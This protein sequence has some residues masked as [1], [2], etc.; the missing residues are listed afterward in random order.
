MPLSHEAGDEIKKFTKCQDNNQALIERMD[1]TWALYRQDKDRYNIPKK[2][3][4]WEEYI[5]NWAV[6]E[7][8]KIKDQL[9]YAKRRLWIPISD[10]MKTERE[11]LSAAERLANGLLYLADSLNENMPEYDSIQSSLVFYKVFRGWTAIRVMLREEDGKVIPDFIAWD[12]RNTGWLSGRDRLTWVCSKRQAQAQ[13]LKDEYP[14]WN[15]S[16]GEKD[17]GL[18]DVYDVYDCS[19][20]G[21][22]AENGVIIKG[23]YVVDPEPIKVGNF[24]LDYLPIRIKPGRSVPQISDGNSDNIK[25]R[26][27]DYLANNRLLI[28]ILSRLMSYKMTRAGQ[29]AKSPVLLGYDSVKGGEAIDFDSN[30]YTKGKVT[31]LDVGK[32]QTLLGNLIPAG[33][34]EIDSTLALTEG[35][36]SKGGIGRVGY[37]I[38]DQALPAQGIDILSQATNDVI[39]PFKLGVEGD[40]EWIASEY[41]RQFKNGGFGKIEVEG[42]DKGNNPYRVEVKAKEVDTNWRFKCELVPD[43]LRDISARIGIASQAVKDKLMSRKTAREY[44]QIVDDVDL[45]ETKI[46]Q[47]DAE[48]IAHI[49]LWQMAV[50]LDKDGD[51]MAAQIILNELKKLAQPQGQPQGQPQPGSNVEGIPRP[52]PPGAMTARRPMPSVPQ[53]V[54]EAASN[55]R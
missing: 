21:K 36:A 53:P 11:K 2:E 41:V 54:R 33:G 3:G 6:T 10:E 34:Q 14:G 17:T 52:M 29:Q 16:D 28:P 46:D 35:A 32:G 22:P 25:M 8:N 7:G 40:I 49:K 31:Q 47:E 39:K 27:E 45:E 44:L 1:L 37:G 13:E 15:G 50:A 24:T 5:V 30:P 12:P 48:S 51:T 19:D 20:P 4:D 26:G 9:S 42:F 38:I 55:A 23:E 43:L 18:I